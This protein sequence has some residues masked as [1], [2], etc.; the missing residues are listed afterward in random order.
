[1]VARSRTSDEV[2]AARRSVDEADATVT[3]KAE[4]LMEMAMAFEAVISRDAMK[5]PEDLTYLFS[6]PLIG[7]KGLPYIEPLA[8]WRAMLG[9]L[10]LETPVGTISARFHRGLAKAVGNMVRR[11]TDDTDIDT[12]ALSGGCFQNATLLQLVCNEVAE[13]GLQS[14]THK[15]VPANDGGLSL[16]QAVIGLTHHKKGV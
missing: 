4:M 15:N 8:V 11:L 9:D 7:G 13:L 10:L 6:I 14:L 3:E 1:M 16:G 2:L 12:V 5:E